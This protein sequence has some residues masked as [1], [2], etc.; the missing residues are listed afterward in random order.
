MTLSTSEVA[1]VLRPN[2]VMRLELADGTV[3]TFE[4]SLAAFHQLRHSVAVMLN[5]MDWAGHELDA[6]HEIG[7]RAQAQWE[8]LKGGLGGGGAD[9]LQLQLGVGKPPT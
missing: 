7:Q 1:R 9:K 4:V 8:K 3:R 6:A 2:V 5:E